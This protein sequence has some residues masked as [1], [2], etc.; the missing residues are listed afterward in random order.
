MP[1][2]QPFEE[3]H[4][5][6]EAWFEKNRNVFQSELRA[7]NH[8]VPKNRKGI[9]IGIGSGRFAK[10]LGVRVGIEPS[11]AMG[12]LA[13]KK[14]LDVCQGVAEDLPFVNGSFDFALMIT[15]ICFLDDLKKSF[16]EVCRILKIKG[17]FI[18]GL[19]DRD[20]PLGQ[21][22][23]SQKAEDRFYKVAEFFSCEQILALLRETGFKK[24]KTIQTLFCHGAS[25]T[26]TQDFEEGYGKGGFV[27][28]KAEKGGGISPYP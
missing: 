16:G 19:I 21:H 1:K 20:S 6:Y 11:R 23:Q 25:D 27:V 3:Y 28:I 2:I 8:F 4:K 5:R 14:G 17:F 7:L 26:Q 9:E 24:P 15:T 13:R 22:Y 18:I 12:K 10:P